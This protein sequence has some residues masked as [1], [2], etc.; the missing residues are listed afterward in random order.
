MNGKKIETILEKLFPI[1][2]AYDWDNVGLQIGSL[3][4]DV[5]TILLSLDITDEVCNEAI[6]KGSELIIVHHPLIFSPLK[7]IKT[8]S[9]IGKIIQKLIQNDIALYVMH[10][11]FDAKENGLNKILADMI[12]LKNT[13]VLSFTTET[14]GIGLYSDI[15]STPVSDL[16]T[17]VKT[18]F[19]LE[20]ARYI[21]D[22][23]AIIKRVA[24]TGGSGSSGI[25]D[26]LKNNVDLYITGDI[27]YH[28]ALDS[29]AH[30][31]NIIDVGHNIE[32]YAIN[33]LLEIL[34]GSDI[35]SELIISKVNTDPYKFV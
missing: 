19:K 35:T 5:N 28:H 21:G 23:D 33:G 8:D 2:L 27:S 9:N 25:K 4:K 17:L 26:C 7:S 14:E 16:I 6:E 13:N 15:D 10:T 11:N 22:L 32:K 1:N 3:N 12:N 34:K 30:G 29:L 20:R 24:I 31:L 18:V